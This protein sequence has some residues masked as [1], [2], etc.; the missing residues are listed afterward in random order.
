MRRY[1]ILSV[2]LVF[3]LLTSCDTFVGDVREPVDE[4]NVE[5]LTTPAD[6][7]FLLTGV[8][9]AWAEGYGEIAVVAS[10]LSDQFRF[11][12]NSDATFPTFRD[13]DEGLVGL[14]NNSNDDFQVTLGEY[15]R[16]S[17][18]LVRAANNAEYGDDPPITQDRALFQAHLHGG[19]ARYLY[20]A[21]VG[22]NPREGGGVIG[23]SEFIPSPA[24]YDSARAKFENARQFASTPRQEK[25]VNSVEARSA[26]YAGTEYGTDAGGYGNAL[27][28]A[29]DRASNGLQPGDDPEQVLYSIQEN[30]PWFFD[31]GPGRVQVVA[32]DGNLN[33]VVSTYQDPSA[34]RSFIDIAENNPDEL[35]RI[36]LSGV[37]ASANFVAIDSDD[38]IE[39]AQARHLSR[40]SPIDFVSWQENHLI[41]AEL[42]LRGF[43]TGNPDALA[44]VNEVRD[45]F[46]LDALSNVDLETI[47][48]ERDRTLFTNGDRLVDQ[49][50]LDVVDWHLVDEF[51]GRTT[52]QYAPIPEQERSANPNL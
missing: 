32:Q 16:L 29:A 17:D 11:G 48:Q 19:I 25:L 35:N 42:E 52:W 40:E 41:R 49:R 18:D 20:A 27:Q 24:M 47:A 10:L 5:E 14:N 23:K 43:D 30:N 26:L 9:A 33:D 6:V 21:Y 50:R 28:A 4:V 45:S 13:L 12:Q 44:L 37:D 46:G 36:P 39:F 2:T 34:V 3:F 15:R 8:Q 7:D 1:L 51:Q 22:L 38:A 31:G